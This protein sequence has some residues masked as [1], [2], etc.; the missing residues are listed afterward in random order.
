MGEGLSP[1][2]VRVTGNVVGEAPFDGTLIHKGWKVAK[3]NLPKIA[4]GHNTAIIA[5]AEVEL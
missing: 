2:E 5:P 3:V 4:E 1:A